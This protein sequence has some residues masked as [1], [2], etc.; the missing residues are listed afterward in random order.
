MNAS[1]APAP[2]PATSA[3]RN[4]DD[5]PRVAGFEQQE[6]GAAFERLLRNKTAAREQR[7]EEE[8]EIDEPPP[9]GAA[10]SW[11]H[12]VTPRT[13]AA[14]TPTVAAAGSATLEQP[15]ATLRAAAAEAIHST[16]ISPLATAETTQNWQ[17]SLS[18]PLGV[19]IE[20]R[21]TRTVDPAAAGP[22]AWAL[23][24]GS[25][26]RDAAVLARQVPRLQERLRARDVDAQV[27]VERDNEVAE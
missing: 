18:E 20:L 27:R 1:S 16:P 22:A 25:S 9:D 21:A 14:P 3:P 26:A 7:H 10:T 24:V 6:A 15:S 8:Q 12:A 5:E 17:V 4:P 11:M 19:P 23:T 2:A 13:A